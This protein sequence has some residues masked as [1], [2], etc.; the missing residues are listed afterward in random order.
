ARL[1]DPR[2]NRQH[3]IYRRLSLTSARLRAW[4]RWFGSGP[5]ALEAAA[6]APRPPLD[7]SLRRVERAEQLGDDPVRRLLRLGAGV[8]Q[9]VE[10][11]C[12]FDLGG[13]DA[14]VVRR[15]AERFVTLAL[16]VRQLGKG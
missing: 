12:S 3:P 2:G 1:R 15:D 16:D 4:G 9:R 13:Q 6:H 10:P 7:I 8:E 5:R 14:G 11:A